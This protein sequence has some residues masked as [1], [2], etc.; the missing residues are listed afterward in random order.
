MSRDR[1]PSCRF[2]APAEPLATAAT[3]LGGRRAGS[4]CQAPHV[5][6]I[7][8]H[9]YSPFTPR[10]QAEREA[11]PRSEPSPAPAGLGGGGGDTA[12]PL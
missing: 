12:P 2:R 8:T 3:G 1:A 9:Q 5:L 7:N 6:V 11:E 4:A 10:L